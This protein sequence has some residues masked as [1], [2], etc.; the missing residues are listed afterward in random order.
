MKKYLVEEEAGRQQMLSQLSK[1][2]RK[3]SIEL[4]SI[5]NCRETFGLTMDDLG[6][7]VPM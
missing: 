1:N 6:L 2:D 7:Q 5:Y 4:N 3:L